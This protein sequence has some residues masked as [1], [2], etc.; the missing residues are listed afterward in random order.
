MIDAASGRQEGRGPIDLVCH[1]PGL[2]SA[3][4]TVRASF[5]QDGMTLWPGEARE[6]FVPYAD[7][8]VS[9]GGFGHDQILLNWNDGSAKWSAAIGDPRAKESFL[10]RVPAALEPA[11]VHWRESVGRVRKRAWAGWSVVALLLFSPV[12][13]AAV[14]WVESDRISRWAADGISPQM[15]RTLGDLIFD[16]T[17]NDL[18]LVEAGEA[19]RI[20]AEIGNRLTAGTPHAFKWHVANDPA[21]NAFAVPGGHV[22]VFTGLLRAAGSAEEAAGVLAHEAQHVVM[23]HSL[24]GL[25]RSLG[26]R[27]VLSLLVG[28]AATETLAGELAVELGLLK[29]SRAQ[30]AEAD[31][32]GLLLLKKAG[33]DPEGMVRF[34]DGLGRREGATIALLSSHPASGDRAESLRAEIARIGPWEARKLPYDWDGVKAALPPS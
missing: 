16:Q 24:R 10:S 34:F 27:A 11:V 5:L 7:I 19:P 23:R 33:I 29:F 20:V 28:S 25:V 26:W 9:A 12:V 17:R 6:R 31:R 22:V 1:G 21:V 13:L 32:E 3:G 8:R 15:E 18:K 30:E 4:E 14:F 2:S